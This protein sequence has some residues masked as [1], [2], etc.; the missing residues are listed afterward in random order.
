M[1]K[2]GLIA[3]ANDGGLGA[4]T[5]RLSQVLQPDRIM[6]I[7]S[8][9]FSPNKSLH[10]EWYPA[11]RSF[12][13]SM[14]PP[15]NNDMKLFLEG[16]THVIVCENPYNFALL[17]YAKEQGIKVYVQ[18]NYEFCE[19]IVQPWLPTPHKFIMPSYWKIAEMEKLFGRQNVEYLPPPIDPKEFEPA[20]K[21]NFARTGKK[22]FVHVIGTGAAEDRNGTFDVLDAMKL[23]KG[24]FELVIKSQHNLP[25]TLF[26]DD[27][28]IK[29]DVSNY[30]DQNELYKNYDALIL[31]RRWGGL[32][33]TMCE[34]LMSA[35]PV[36]MT[37]ITPN[38]EYLPS[39]WLVPAKPEKPFR[40]RIG[41]IDLVTAN[42]Q[43]LADKLDSWAS[44]GNPVNLKM[45][46]MAYEIAI[47]NWSAEVLK[48]QYLELF[49]NR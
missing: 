31:P 25:M 35:L 12:L 24:D 30:L 14:W 23:S 10:Y 22:R 28:R 2:L 29:Y 1:V 48:P 3:F 4:Q 45:K 39:S 20:R 36:M 9:S 26:L 37:D 5:R 6:M 16:L 33:L 44:K 7:D 8:S 13:A 34:A 15:S 32:C 17:H 11:D 21:V 43:A 19:N 27:P 47:R 46:E 42:H 18:S 49:N 38:K 40:S 41:P